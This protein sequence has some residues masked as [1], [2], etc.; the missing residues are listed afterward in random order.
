VSLLAG[1]IL[2]L[3]TPFTENG[4]VNIPLLQ[5]LVE[6]QLSQQA[7]G[8][9]VAG[10][11]GEGFLMTIKERQLVAETVIQQV[12]NRVPV[13]IQVGAL[14]TL[15]SVALAEGAEVAG[16]DGVSSTPPFYYKT[17]E[18]G[19]A[20]HFAAIGA[21]SSL[22][23]YLY[24]FPQTTGVLVSAG[25]FARLLEQVPSL[26]G[27][28]YTSY[29]FSD[30]LQIIDVCR[31]R[32][33]ILSGCDEIFLPALVMG[34]DGAISATANYMCWQFNQIYSAFKTGDLASAQEVQSRVNRLIAV[35]ESYDTWAAFKAPLSFL[36]FDIDDGRAP[37]RRLADDERESLK[38]DLK[39]AGFFELQRI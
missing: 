8:F 11:T 29:S 9:F 16:A 18:R 17:D 26:A 35:L 5:D 36:G 34:V 1:P 12:R 30:L 19:L 2:A 38:E 10:S 22:P 33:N 14:A 28:K 3:A 13:V 39:T 32:S 24:N 20:C 31:G 4:E 7:R 23:L 21:A 25:Q 37:I 6:W 15:D 27:M